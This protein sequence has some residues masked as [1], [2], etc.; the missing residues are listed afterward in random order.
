VPL[1]IL[2]PATPYTVWRRRPTGDTARGMREERVYIANQGA[3]AIAIA[4]VIA[5]ANGTV[6][7]VV[8]NRSEGARRLAEASAPAGLTRSYGPDS[9]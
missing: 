3:I 4:I 6:P 2:A 8:F 7:L 1:S 5:I 9:L